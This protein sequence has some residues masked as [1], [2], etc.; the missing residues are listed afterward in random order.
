MTD[1]RNKLTRGG[2]EWA[3]A[4]AFYLAGSLQVSRI[5]VRTFFFS[6]INICLPTRRPLFK[7]CALYLPVQ[8]SQS[9]PPV[10]PPVKSS[11]DKASLLILT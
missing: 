3:R 5:A 4:A 7:R 9:L 8:C 2:G 11:N 6:K 1:Q 10:L